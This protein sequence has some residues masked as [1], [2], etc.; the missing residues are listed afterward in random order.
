MKGFAVSGEIVDEQGLWVKEFIPWTHENLSYD[1]ETEELQ[2]YGRD[3]CYE[4]MV[5]RQYLVTGPGGFAPVRCLVEIYDTSVM[6][7]SAEEF[8]LEQLGIQDVGEYL[9]NM[10]VF[11]DRSYAFHVLGYDR[12]GE[13]YTIT[14]NRIQ[15]IGPEGETE[16]A[17]VLPVYLEKGVV[18]KIDTG[19]W[20]N[21]DCLCDADGNSYVRYGGL[22]ELYILDRDGKLL[23]E[24]KGSSE[25]T[26]GEPMKTAEGELIFPVHSNENGSTHTRLVWFDV[27]AGQPRILAD[28][29]REWVKQLYGMQGN[30]LYYEGQSGIVRWDVVSGIRQLV[31]RFAE[32]G[33]FDSSHIY[34]TMLLLSEEKPP[35][36]RFYQPANNEDDWMAVLTEEPEEQSGAVR[37]VSLVKGVGRIKDCAAVVSRK[38][39]NYLFTYEDSGKTDPEDFRTRIIAELVAGNGPDI[40]YVSREDMELLQKRGLLADLRTFLSEE[41]IDKV[42][43]GVI[44]LGTVDGTLVGMA[45]GVSARSL[46][47]GESVF[48]GESW[49]LD[50]MVELM[51]SGQLEGRIRMSTGSYYYPLAVVRTLVDHSLEN[52]FL[53]DWE[54]MESHF[55]DERF[56]RL[57]QYAGRY[58]N[59]T[60]EGPLD[61]RA[62]GGGSL[63]VEVSLWRPESAIDFQGT[64]GAEGSHYVGFP[65]DAGNGSYLDVGGMLVVK[66]NPSDPEAVSAY[67]EGL[68]GSEIQAM[69]DFMDTYCIPVTYF[70]TDEIQYDAE[71]GEAWWNG[72]QL[73]V[74]EDG[75]T[76]LHEANEFLARCVPAPKTY[77]DLE[78]IIYEELSAYF[79]ETDRTAADTARILD[80]RI[81]VYLDE[82]N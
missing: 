65:T 64:R 56:I 53:I 75:T 28:L 36:L 8:T 81:Q 26:I 49:T 39:R 24:Y 20:L 78:R 74:F 18:R 69:E 27:E 40:L 50:D 23:M 41:T 55:E 54:N 16:R 35:I 4:N 14:S 63:M 46:L 51:K 66:K 13:E 47:I 67:L 5:Y 79:E 38:N 30:Y 10:D 58:D 44:E 12:N 77:A 82:R 80:N 70:P 25:E 33:V 61:D 76:S 21:G 19:V 6:E 62:A 15:Y 72:Y 32:N 11:G 3:I 60:F 37:V 7:T 71:T 2:L 17:D 57:L 48:S 43:P 29:N 42:M 59:G 52:S 31:F 22:T 73:T 68:W 9:G 1:E 34:S 45:S